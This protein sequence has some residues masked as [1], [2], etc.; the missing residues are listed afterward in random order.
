MTSEMYYKGSQ[1]A[2]T[3]KVCVSV[4]VFMNVCLCVCVCVCVC[5]P[6]SLKG[7]CQARRKLFGLRCEQQSTLEGSGVRPRRTPE[8]AT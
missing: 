4:C 3:R 8:A 7:V 6:F 1:R 5:V 2:G